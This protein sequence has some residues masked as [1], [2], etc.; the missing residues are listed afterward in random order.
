M[1][2]VLHHAR[3]IVLAV[4]VVLVSGGALYT[5]LNSPIASLASPDTGAPHPVVEGT[6]IVDARSGREF[7][8][9]GVNWSSFEYACA[10]GWGY[11]ALDN[12]VA[13]DPYSAEA[14]MIA[15]WG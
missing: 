3:W 10:Q 5:Q 9:R 13:L 1:R 7:V 2:H 4:V 6:R 14:K 8:P 11:S 15:K 12:V